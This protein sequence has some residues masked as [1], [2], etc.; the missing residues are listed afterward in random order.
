MVTTIGVI[1]ALALSAIMVGNHNPKD[2]YALFGDI[3]D[4]F[5]YPD[6]RITVKPCQEIDNAF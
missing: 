2:H 4:T 3:L 6:V 1:P 5:A